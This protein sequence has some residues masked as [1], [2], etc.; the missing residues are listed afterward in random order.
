MRC[1]P[2]VWHSALVIS[3]RT[4]RLLCTGGESARNT[5][6]SPVG[7]VKNTYRV[8]A[9]NWKHVF[10]WDQIRNAT[11]SFLKPPVLIS[12]TRW[13]L[14]LFRWSSAP[15]SGSSVSRV[16][17]S[18]R[19]CSISYPGFSGDASSTPSNT[20]SARSARSRAGM[21]KQS[22]FPHSHKDRD[23]KRPQ[24]THSRRIVTEGLAQ[25]RTQVALGK[26]NLSQLS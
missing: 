11:A 22:G 3:F 24:I 18:T 6:A 1:L 5:D 17:P 16:I 20:T 14:I 15:G 13:T 21:E 12:H 8:P 19:K 26:G 25:E 2:Y 7:S 9:F 4:A 23:V 10:S